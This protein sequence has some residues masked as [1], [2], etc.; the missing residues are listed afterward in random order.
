MASARCDVGN[1]L[2]KINLMYKL[3]A[4]GALLKGCGGDDKDGG[5]YHLLLVQGF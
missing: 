5:Y 1:V 4:V 3:G 2:F